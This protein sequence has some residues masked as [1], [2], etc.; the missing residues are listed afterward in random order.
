[1]R[2]FFAA[3][4]GLFQALLQHGDQVDDLGW[5]ALRGGFPFGR[6]SAAFDLFLDQVEQGMLVIVVVLSGLLWI[7]EAFHQLGGHFEFAAADC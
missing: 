5:R 3:F 2:S 1:M 7:A 6:T 4:A